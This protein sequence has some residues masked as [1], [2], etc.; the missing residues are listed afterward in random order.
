MSTATQ[1][2]TRLG[3]PEPRAEVP[4]GVPGLREPL[5]LSLPGD[6]LRDDDIV[7][8]LPSAD[9]ID[10]LAPAFADPDL[11][12]AGNLPE[13]D[14]DEILATLPYLPALAAD[15]RLLP[16]VVAEAP[17]GD[18]LGGAALHHLDAER[19]IVELGYWLFPHARGRG[20]ATRVARLLAEHAFA[21]GVQRVAAY[22]NVGNRASERVLERAGFSRE[23]VIR[24]LPKPD[25][26][27]VD[28]TLYSL[29]LGE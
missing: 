11:R 22:V 4:R 16:V 24:S 7:L 18:V 8:R 15:G 9:D 28:K 10:E 17:R 5:E 21:L 13:L 6:G 25:G 20:F 12:E 14:R 3:R 29:L 2:A 19:G 27:R 1:A 23:G 26:R